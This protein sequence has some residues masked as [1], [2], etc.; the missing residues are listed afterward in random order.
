MADIDLKTLTPDTTVATGAVFFGA[1][2]QAASSPSVYP[3]ADVA[4]AM[5]SDLASTFAASSHT[6]ASSAITDF[7]EAVDD[8][9]AALLVAGSNITL[10]YNDGANTLTV[11]ASGSSGTVTSVDITAPAA[12]ITA[13]GGPITTSGAI[14]LALANDLAAVEGLSTNGLAARTASD[15]WTARSVAAGTGI[16]VTNGD[17]VAGNPTVA[18]ATANNPVGKHTIW[19]PAAAMTARTTNGAASGTTELATNDIML[20]T[21][22]FDTSTEEGAGILIAMP[23][24]WNESTITFEPVWTAASGSGGVVWGL[25][26]YS[27]S[28]DDALDTAVSGQQTS[29]DTLLAANDLHIGPA[30]SAIT[31]GGTP[32]EGDVVYLEVTRE[33]ADGSD[34]LAVDA[35]LIGIRLIFT[36]NAAT[37]D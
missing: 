11:A 5:A 23:K 1:D 32:A 35:K 9:V 26:G 21:L 18:L 4:S 13:S 3:R 27:F 33:V 28:N 10:T 20:R 17:G 15:T 34:T 36:V 37:D 19:I 8:R 22:D 24:S 2:S 16:S 31:L 6:H 29:T 14:T 7:S 30:S 12:G 25:A